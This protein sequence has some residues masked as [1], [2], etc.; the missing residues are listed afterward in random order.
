MTKRS[1]ARLA[2]RITWAAVVALVIVLLVGLVVAAVW[3]NGRNDELANRVDRAEASQTQM[4]GD[5]DEQAAAAEALE[6]QLRQLGEQ[7]VVVPDDVDDAPIV[8]TGQKGDRGPSCIEEIGYPRCRGAA[9]D[10]GANGSGGSVGASCVAELGLEACRGPAGADG[11]NGTDGKDGA[12]GT[13]GR[14]IKD[15]QCGPDGR[16]AI[17]YTD[18]TTSDGGNCL[19]APGNSGDNR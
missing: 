6:Q 4:K 16:W 7:P 13:D 11:K 12:P 14:G 5:L 18:G 2:L 3:L 8:I 17:T 10:D 19:V 15:A 9:G 1:R